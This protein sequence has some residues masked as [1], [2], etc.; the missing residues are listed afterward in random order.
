M[1][2]LVVFVPETHLEPLKQALFAAGA[3]RIGDY[4]HCSWQSL[5]EGQFRPLPGSSP[6][7]GESE[8]LERVAEYRLETVVS[9]AIIE[10]VI[11]ALYR[12]HPYEEP[13][14]DCWRVENFSRLKPKN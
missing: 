2:K 1:Y 14:Y 8:R 5:G 10:L 13:A 11:E 9:D 6:F 7:I 4:D 3:G 12:A